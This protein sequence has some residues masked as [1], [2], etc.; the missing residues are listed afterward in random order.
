MP[1]INNKTAYPFDTNL[2]LDD[3]VIGSDADN[4]DVT[5]NYPLSGLFSTFK[6]S[7]NLASLSFA[8]AGG[9]DPD[10]DFNDAGYF[11]T[12][13]NETS[14]GA[15]VTIKINKV[16][17]GAVDMSSLVETIAL[18]PSSF[19]FRLYK[20][21]AIGQ[22]FFYAITSIVDNITYYTF[23]VSNF[24]GAGT[25]GDETTYSLAFDL[26]GVPSIYTETDT[27][28]SVTARGATTAV[29]S[30]FTSGLTVTAVDGEV[31]SFTRSGNANLTIAHS[32]TGDLSLEKSGSGNIL[33]D[34]GIVSSILIGNWN[35]AFGWGDHGAAGYITSY[36]ETDPVFTASDVFS[37]TTA[38]IASWTAVR[39]DVTSLR[40]TQWDTAFGWGDHGAA[41]YITSY[42]ET[43]PVFLAHA[44]A[45]VTTIKMNEWDTA[46]TWGDHAAAGYL[47][48]VFTTLTTGA[49]ESG[50]WTKVATITLD[51][52]GANASAFLAY[53]N[54][55]NVQANAR[56]GFITFR[57]RQEAALGFDP[58]VTA[59]STFMDE[60]SVDVGYIIVQNT[61]TSI[62]EF[63]VQPNNAYSTIHATA[64]SI[65]NSTDIVWHSGLTYATTPAGL[66]ETATTKIILQTDID[67][68]A[69]LNAIITDATLVDA[70][71]THTFA[72]L[73]SK[74]TTI[75]G[76]GITDF[77]SLGDAEWAQLVHT[78]TF[79]SLTS[80][81]TTIS[82]Y[83]ITDAYTKS[84]TDGK[85]LLNT[86]DTFTGALTIENAGNIEFN[87]NSTTAALDE[88]SWD[89]VYTSGGTL[90]WRAVNDANTLATSFMVVD[91]T[92]IV[93]N[94]IDLS[95]T[96]INQTG[97]VFLDGN[98]F[99]TATQYWRVS[100]ANDANQRAD[101]RAE[102]TGA[103]LHWYGMND[104]VTTGNTGVQWNLYDGSSYTSFDVISDTIVYSGGITT[105]GN[106]TSAGD[107]IGKGAGGA[108][109]AWGGAVGT[110]N[111][112]WLSFHDSAGTRQGYM[113]FGSGGNDHMYFL[114]DRTGQYIYLSDAAG[115]NGF[116]FHDGTSTR[117]VWHEGN[118]PTIDNMA[119]K[120][121]LGALEDLNNYTTTGLY[122]QNA[123]VDASGGTNYPSPYAGML[124]VKEGDAFIYQEYQEYQGYRKQW[125][126]QKYV[127]TWSAW[128]LVYDSASKPLSASGNRWD[129]FTEVAASG[130]MEVGR[131]I[132]FH[133]T[134]ADVTD[135]TTRFDNHVNGQVRMTS[136]ATTDIFE[137]SNSSVEYAQ[138]A[139]NTGGGYL[140][141]SDDVLTNTIIRG[142][143]NSDFYAG[144]I[145]INGTGHNLHLVSGAVTRGAHNSGYLEGSYNNVGSNALNSNPIYTIGS[146]YVPASTTLSN[147]YG[148][149]YSYYTATF[150]NSTD[151]GRTPAGW[152]M[153][154]AAD[155][156]ARIFLNASNGI[157]Y[158]LGI[159]YAS[160]FTLNSD[161]RRKNSIED[162]EVKDLPVRWRS[163]ELNTEKG[164]YR[165][166]VIAQELLEIAPEFVDQSDPDDLS[167]NYFDLLVAKMAEKDRQMAEKDREIE[168]LESRMEILEAKLELLIKN[169]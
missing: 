71:H 19:I 128:S 24:V 1:K 137:V 89:Y 124:T 147:M 21:S 96:A 160:N 152:G 116:Q 142:Y 76:Y 115:T 70:S 150:L 156:N 13:G 110:G 143:G 112:T 111:S 166:G 101:A 16:D 63:Y 65:D 73:T 2:S 155:G 133:S 81:P 93:I 163:F 127:S 136:T 161:I 68:L 126:R 92:G 61:P 9:S 60:T 64:I 140:V 22:V 123:N 38:D 72:S 113:G 45:G 11:T 67:T 158:Q 168:S 102:G 154:A 23:T 14:A 132:D 48:N 141:L 59:T 17:L 41:G 26:A 107:I 5:R 34:G 39:N 148:I 165:A 167:V 7:L 15:V 10:L 122:H 114:S 88:K 145:N 108:L 35:T 43:D 52:Q 162:I 104:T 144:S 159:S 57:S 77:V 98:Q 118:R 40:L 44:A 66:V 53:H 131:Y 29:A 90:S 153:Y 74:P 51:A 78:H 42:T 146:S 75:A 31:M 46:Y 30:S 6:S 54:S 85:Y 139:A 169:M 103:R 20:P 37:V 3:F 83:G 28:A 130:I 87:L 58:L 95:A 138:L 151:L 157:T 50:K 91:R 100:N 86:T 79:A 120:S 12:N 80:K 121:D 32:G 27:L 25:L 49:T 117:A 125:R 149:G 82:G 56:A 36:T 4:V 134:D 106:I 97:N 99:L 119:Y 18:Q 62:V 109:Q 55:T 47:G 129:V 164:Q 33:I 105:T 69:E 8:F 135:Y 94:S 84:Q